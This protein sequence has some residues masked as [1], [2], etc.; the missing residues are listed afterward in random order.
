MN[1][2]HPLYTV[3]HSNLELASFLATLHRYQIVLLIDVRSRPQS[4]RFPHFSQDELEPA[5]R[6]AAIAYLPLGEELGGRPGDPRAYR[7]DGLVDYKRRR[8]SREF[9]SGIER[10]LAETEKNSLALMCAEEDPL[11]CHRFLL[12]CPALAELSL[13]PQHI[14]KTG[15]ESQQEA[16]DR[17]LREHDYRDV[18][19]GSLFA[20]NSGERNAA[21]EDA[22]V[23]QAEKFG[24]RA[25]P[26]QLAEF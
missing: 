1:D 25:D 9:Q 17:L 7:N 24:F 20:S 3:G 5:L 26:R 8:G 13:A 2:R 14:R 23:K 12:I 16:E 19:S 10:V 21:L 6:D 22:Y 15:V 11:E 18:A 4:S